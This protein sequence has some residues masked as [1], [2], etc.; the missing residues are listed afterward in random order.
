VIDNMD[1]LL[2]EAHKTKG[3]KWV[4]EPLWITWPMENFVTSIAD[5][6]VPY[7]RSLNMHIEIVDLLRNHSTPFDMARD[8]LS[9]WS[10][11]PW[12][13]ENGWEAKWEDLCAVEVDRWDMV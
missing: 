9:R 12:L 3:W 4:Q 6:L 10:G 11:Q 1:T 8:A 7:H 2:F 13:E 5:I